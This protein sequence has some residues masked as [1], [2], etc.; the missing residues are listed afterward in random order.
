MLSCMMNQSSYGIQASKHL[1]IFAKLVGLDTRIWT[2]AQG[3][4]AVWNEGNGCE[5]DDIL[6]E[7]LT[8][9]KSQLGGVVKSSRLLNWRTW[10]EFRLLC[11]KSADECPWGKSQFSQSSLTS[12]CL[13]RCWLWGEDGEVI[14]N[15]FVI[16][17]FV[18]YPFGQFKV[19][20]ES[21]SS[22]SNILKLGTLLWLYSE[23]INL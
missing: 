22:F 11:M 20:Y 19:G 13:T 12:I 14:E 3:I 16:Y 8:Q 23:N 2:T 7:L 9:Y 1:F 4:T 6:E 15:C 10:F 17:P 5:I 18:N 21:N